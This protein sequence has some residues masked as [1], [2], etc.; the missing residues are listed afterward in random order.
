MTS[1]LPLLGLLGALGAFDTVYFH[2]WR[3]R[4]PA[5]GGGIDTELRLHAARDAI[6]VVVFAT[7]PWLAWQ[8]AWSV[9]LAGLFAAEIVITLTDFVV[10]D[11]VRRPLGGVYPG[12]RVTHA[13][14]AIV[15]GAML[16]RLVP[17]LR[18]WWHAPT[19]LVVARPD[20]VPV[21]LRLAL[22]AMAAGILVSG[23]RDLY[24]SMGG[25]HGAWPWR[26][27]KLTEAG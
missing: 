11:R 6:Y 17:V 23:A 20:D 8:G 16:A 5:R 4:L 3:G 12:E 22:V 26:A 13:L 18:T 10:E 14:M 21:A 27:G 7:L 15:Y 24:A 1:V 2:E 25:P 9:V 19:R